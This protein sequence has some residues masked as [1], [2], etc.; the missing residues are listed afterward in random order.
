MAAG[1][2]K[3]DYSPEAVANQLEA[4][5]EAANGLLAQDAG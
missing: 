4:A 2:G 1:Q 5:E 3:E